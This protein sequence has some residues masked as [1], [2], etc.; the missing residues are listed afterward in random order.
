MK[1]LEIGAQ[2]KLNVASYYR[3]VGDDS[4]LKN[5]ALEQ[6]KKLITEGN[7]EF[8]FEIFD[9]TND[10]SEVVQALDSMS[11]TADVKI[12]VA[13]GI[14]EKIDESLQK[15]LL[16]IAQESGGEKIFISMESGNFFEFL[17]EFSVEVNCEKL[18]AQEAT[19]YAKNLCE[20]N[21]F[22]INN[23]DLREIVTLCGLDLGSIS[24]E[25]DKLFMYAF[26]R[27]DK[28][29]TRL[30]IDLLTS[31]EPELKIFELTNALQRGDKQKVLQVY[32]TLLERGEKANYILAIIIK[33]YRTYFEIAISNA[34]DDTLCKTL[35]I[36]YSALMVNKKIVDNAKKTQRG[37]VVGL[38]KTIDYLYELEFMFKSGEVTVDN[39]LELAITR[40][41]AD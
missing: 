32:K 21:G 29:I 26:D 39:A 27:D 10:F 14:K 9:D 5:Y 23:S 28:T 2:L 15:Q 6:F 30:D 19:A 18:T 34:A 1:A 7:E 24:I 35:G 20:E 38:K 37:Y 22:K 40:L 13:R 25:L 8:C 17:R 36:S 3:F 11:L 4:F 16:Q 33:A 12:V 31:S 41:I